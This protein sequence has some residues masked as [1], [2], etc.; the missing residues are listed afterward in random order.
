MGAAVRRRIR[1]RARLEARLHGLGYRQCDAQLHRHQRPH[2]AVGKHL[3]GGL[4]AHGLEVRPS[5]AGC[6]CGGRLGAGGGDRSFAIGHLRAFQVRSGGRTRARPA[7]QRRFSAAA[8]SAAASAPQLVPGGVQPGHPDALRQAGHQG[9][10]ARPARTDRRADVG[11]RTA[12][13]TGGPAAPPQRLGRFGRLGRL[14]YRLGILPALPVAT[15]SQ[16]RTSA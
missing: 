10:D 1:H 14:G 16:I 5:V 6:G 2:D 11:C 3:A 4:V 12:V 15:G 8:A 13:H 9:A 7:G